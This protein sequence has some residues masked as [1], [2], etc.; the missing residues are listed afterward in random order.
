MKISNAGCESTF[1]QL[2]TKNDTF[3]VGTV[4]RHPN[5]NPK[6]FLDALCDKLEPI[7]SKPHKYKLILLGDINIDTYNNPRSI[8]RDYLNYIETMG[9][10]KN[11]HSVY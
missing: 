10:K 4:Y 1:I 11:Y 6:V 8:T 9:C 3:V 2:T 5:E 7:L